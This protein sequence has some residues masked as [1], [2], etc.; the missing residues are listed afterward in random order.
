M[1]AARNCLIFYRFSATT[2][3]AAVI[4]LFIKE[5]AASTLSTYKIEKVN[6]NVFQAKVCLVIVKLF[7]P[8]EY[9]NLTTFI[10]I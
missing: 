10:I 1:M 4:K 3:T 8:F 2:L 5:K 6:T 7:F 9:Y